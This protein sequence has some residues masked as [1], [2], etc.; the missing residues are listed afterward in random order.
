M[1]DERAK[2]VRRFMSRPPQHAPAPPTSAAAAPSGESRLC[3]VVPRLRRKHLFAAS[4]AGR[5]ER[6]R[7]LEGHPCSE[8][9]DT[10]AFEPSER[11]Q[12]EP[13]VLHTAGD[14]DRARTHLLT[15]RQEDAVRPAVAIETNGAAPDGDLGAELLGLRQRAACQGLPVSMSAMRRRTNAR[16]KTGCF[17]ALKCFV[18]CR[19]SLRELA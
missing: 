5:L 18:V 13:P 6:T 4:T 8:Q 19:F 16:R 17:V 11:R 10:G 7:P 2:P 3:R 9:V 1:L 14:H 15:V 12:V